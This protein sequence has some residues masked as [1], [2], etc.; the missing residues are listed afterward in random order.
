MQT[1]NLLRIGTAA[2]SNEEAS[3]TASTTNSHRCRIPSKSALAFDSPRVNV[4]QQHVMLMPLPPHCATHSSPPSDGYCRSCREDDMARGRDPLASRH[5]GINACPLRIVPNF[6]ATEQWAYKFDHRSEER[7]NER[8]QVLEL[9][10]QHL[11]RVHRAITD[12]N[13]RR[14]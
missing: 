12:T 9:L 11:M 7:E 13:H 2:P 5:R 3:S 8:A 14:H 10:R 1:V 6:H 4:Q